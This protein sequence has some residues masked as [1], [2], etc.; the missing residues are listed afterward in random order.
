MNKLL[1][2][3]FFGFLMLVSV[4][5]VW[6]MTGTVEMGS[7]LEILDARGPGLTGRST[8]WVLPMALEL[9][10]S[11]WGRIR[12]T[13]AWAEGRYKGRAEPRIPGL[14]PFRID[15][16]GE[17]NPK[18]KAWGRA[19]FSYRT[20]GGLGLLRQ[21]RVD[22]SIPLE[23]GV[24][25]DF[26]GGRLFGLELLGGVKLARGRWTVRIWAQDE[27]PFPLEG[28]SHRL[29]PGTAGGIEFRGLLGK[30]KRERVAFT[31]TGKRMASYGWQGGSMP[32]LGIKGNYLYG[33]RLEG[34]MMPWRRGALGLMV[35]QSERTHVRQPLDKGSFNIL[36]PHFR[37]GPRLGAVLALHHRLKKG[38]QLSISGGLHRL[39]ANGDDPSLQGSTRDDG[40]SAYVLS[41]S[42]DIPLSTVMGTVARVSTTVS[43]DRGVSPDSGPLEVGRVRRSLRAQILVYKIF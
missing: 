42:G 23:D 30:E 15:L 41:W 7:T 18:A 37:T 10:V 25:T 29:D 1:G 40:F 4:P 22:F 39:A 38:P 21:V 9:D 20:A 43:R 36:W 32:P 33:L 19:S 31:L 26:G 35:F 17:T 11:S 2:P 14:L 34:W 8:E 6:P 5:T 13:W 16:S 27:G 28:E 3:I 12:T 24:Q